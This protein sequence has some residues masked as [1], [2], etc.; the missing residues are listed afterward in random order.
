V[1]AEGPFADAIRRHLRGGGRILDAPE[2]IPT[3]WGDGGEV[4]WAEGES[5]LIVG[6]Q[7]VGKGTLMQQLALRRA[8]VL[9]GDLIGYPA[10]ADVEKLTLYLALDRPA[11]I[12]RS[13]KRIVADEDADALDRRFALWAGPLPVDITKR[14]E[15]LVEF[16]RAV[17][18]ARGVPVGTVCADSTKDVA[19]KLSTDEVGGAINRALGA[20]VAEGIETVANHHQRKASSENKKPTKLDD[21][22]GSTWITAGAGSVILLWGQPGDPVVEMTHLKQPAE[23][24][25]PLELHHDHEHGVTTRRDR[26]DAWTVLQGAWTTGVTA[27]EVAEAVYGSATPA[28]REK[29]RRRLERFVEQGQAV[30]IEPPKQ[31]DPSLYRPTGR[32]SRVTPRDFSGDPSRAGSRG[33][34]KPVDTAH[35]PLTLIDSSASPIRGRRER[36]GRG[37]SPKSALGVEKPGNAITEGEGLG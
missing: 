19:S 21:V 9:T 25:G 35:A 27:S 12:I 7:G 24:V 22:Y 32:N 18:D 26:L 10:Q 37:A 30:K 14:P 17:G 2:R 16:V 33:S 5:L 31:G 1:T 20:L 29:A 36:E 23:E 4:L 13:L 3:L 15:S 28:Q 11:Q 34:R 6:P 8:G